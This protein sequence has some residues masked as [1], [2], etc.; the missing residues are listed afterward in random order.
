MLHHFVHNF[1]LSNVVINDF[2]SSEA[3]V[4]PFV[5][6]GESVLTFTDQHRF[7]RLPDVVMVFLNS[8]GSECIISGWTFL[9]LSRW[10]VH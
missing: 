1:P 3:E 2:G 9:G 4:V 8:E 6:F 10:H 5:H 7:F